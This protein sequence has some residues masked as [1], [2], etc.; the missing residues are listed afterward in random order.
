MKIIRYI[1][2]LAAVAF[3]VA[4]RTNVDLGEWYAVTVYPLISSGLSFAVS[5]IPFSMEE[6]LMAGIG[7]IIIAVAIR[8][9]RQRRLKA[10]LTIAEIMIWT[11]IWFYF[12]WGMNYF[13][14]S[15]YSRGEIERQKYEEE[16]FSNFLQD[17]ADNLNSSYVVMPG[18]MKYDDFATDIKGRFENIPVQYG[19]SE[20]KSWQKPK[21][22]LFNGLYSAVGVIGYIGPFFSE[23]Q[24]NEDI[25]T[26]QKPFSYAHELSHLLGVSNEDEA[27]FWAYQLCRHSE[28]PE[29]RY[30][31]YF[32]LLPYV[33]SNASRVMTE[34]EYKEYQQKIRPEILQQ[35]IEQQNFWNSK[36]SKTLGT[37]QSRIY[38][39]MLKGNK[40]SS[41]TKNYMQVIDLII[42]TEYSSK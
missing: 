32:S 28:I 23:I 8:G 31:G 11:I 33:L 22:L 29:V 37:I 40:I 30:S 9:I 26:T 16:T 15:I 2:L 34:D 17:Y 24:V 25:L 1:T 4:A 19:L 20:P 35:L 27:N 6:I 18:T 38:D 7:I 5:W 12:G 41:G 21:N 39:A 3:I 42:A 14:E 10:A 36:Y 13:R